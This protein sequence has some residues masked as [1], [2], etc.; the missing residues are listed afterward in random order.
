MKEKKKT[1]PVVYFSKCK[2]LVKSNLLDV[3]ILSVELREKG[4]HFFFSFLTIKVI[5]VAGKRPTQISDF[6][7]L[8]ILDLI[9]T[10]HPILISSEYSIENVS[11]RN[12]WRDGHERVKRSANSNDKLIDQI[13]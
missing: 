6:F 4:N 13:S 7:Q 2:N 1:S 5:Q 8:R 9:S 11:K 10:I 3:Y 12:E